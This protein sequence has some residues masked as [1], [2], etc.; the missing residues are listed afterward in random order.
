MVERLTVAEVVARTTQYLMSKGIETARLD[1]ELL[2][3]HALGMSRL[4]LY[5]DRD[6]PLNEEELVRARELVRRRAAH[7]PVAYITG[8][9]EF[10]GRD[11]EVTPA[12]LIPRPETELLV[13]HVAEQLLERFPEESVRVLEFGVGSGAIAVTLA[14]LREDLTVVATEIS[15]EAASV[16]RRNAERYNVAGRV[17]IRV[18][19]D[20]SGI[21]GTFHALVSNPPY[22]AESEATSLPPDVCRYEPPLALYAGVDGMRWIEWLLAEGRHFVCHEGGFLAME[23]GFGMTARVREAARQCGWEIEAVQPDYAGIDRIIR[24]VPLSKTA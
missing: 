19:P 15:S 13:E 18:Q 1:A 17:D 3:G 20:F 8:K 9:K 14:L 22:I 16:A 4:E 10:Y 12:V 23:I 5:L 11:F 6:R 7:E 2:I 24:C 21:E